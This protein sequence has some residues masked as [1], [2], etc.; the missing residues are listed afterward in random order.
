MTLT[1]PDS[2]PYYW[3]SDCEGNLAQTEFLKQSFDLLQ[4]LAIIS[5]SNTMID[6][7]LLVLLL[8]FVLAFVSIMSQFPLVANWMRK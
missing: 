3:L 7:T 8:H 2:K 4:L 6:L 5:I 1:F